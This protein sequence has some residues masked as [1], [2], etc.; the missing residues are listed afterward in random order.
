[1][2]FLN[3]LTIITTQT[4]F[5]DVPLHGNFHS[6]SRQSDSFDL[7]QIF[8]KTIVGLQPGDAVTFVDNHEYDFLAL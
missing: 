4:S 5:F 2:L 3:F 6:A 7:R 1:M 8:K